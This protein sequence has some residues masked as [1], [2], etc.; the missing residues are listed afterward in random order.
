MGSNFDCKPKDC[1]KVLFAVFPRTGLDS[2]FKL[3]AF[4]RDFSLIYMP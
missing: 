1:F 4:F 3:A 2:S